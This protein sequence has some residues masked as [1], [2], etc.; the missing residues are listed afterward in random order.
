MMFLTLLK[1]YFDN[2][3]KASFVF[4]SH[5][6][7]DFQY[8]CERMMACYLKKLGFNFCFITIIKPFKITSLFFEYK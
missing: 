4:P 5:T 1:L 7:A 8:H 2:I 3:D 6:W